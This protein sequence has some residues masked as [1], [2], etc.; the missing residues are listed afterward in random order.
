M[1]A[2]S[3]ISAATIDLRNLRTRRLTKFGYFHVGGI[4]TSAVKE[5]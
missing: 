2:T 4:K 3:R 5:S 1:K